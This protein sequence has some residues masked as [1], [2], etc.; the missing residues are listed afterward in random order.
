MALSD[1]K[2]EYI[3]VGSCCA[4]IFWIKQQLEDFELKVNKVPLMC[5]NTSSIN[6]TKNQIQ[7]Q[8]S[9]SIFDK[10][11]FFLVESKPKPLSYL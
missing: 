3:A 4:Q 7:S 9:F 8:V 2:A 5:D 11:V 10:L 1:A 6:L